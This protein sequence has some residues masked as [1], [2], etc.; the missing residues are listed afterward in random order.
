MTC[1]SLAES[2]FS[3]NNTNWYRSLEARHKMRLTKIVNIASKIL[4]NPQRLFA[5]AVNQ[6]ES[7]NS[8]L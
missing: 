2:V 8:G 4:L 6:E 7:N 1:T 5:R 3:Y